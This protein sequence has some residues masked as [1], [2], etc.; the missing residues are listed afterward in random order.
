MLDIYTSEQAPRAYRPRDQHSVWR[1]CDVEFK[2]LSPQFGISITV[3]TKFPQEGQAETTG[4]KVDFSKE[5]Y[6]D[7]YSTRSNFKLM[8]STL[9]ATYQT[10]SPLLK[11]ITGAALAYSIDN[12][13]FKVNTVFPNTITG[14]GHLPLTQQTSSD[15][16]FCLRNQ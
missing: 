9:A 6:P 12:R 4:S 16:F 3:S 7:S 14:P 5:G 13:Q 11:G 15:Q 8:N 1:K 10:V 2:E